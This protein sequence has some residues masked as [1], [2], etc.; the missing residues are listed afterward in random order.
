MN[1]RELRPF[2][3]GPIKVDPSLIL[4]PMSGVTNSCFRRL[5]RRHNPRA[6]GLVVTE[7]ISI[8]GLTRENLRSLEMMRFREEERPISIQIFGHDV[9]RMAEAAKMVEAAGADILDIN[10]GCPVP[11]VVRRG[12]GC[13]LMR[14]PDQMEKI[15]KA[16]RAAIKIPLT[17]KIRSGWNEECIN[18][19]EIARLAE[20]CGVQMLAVHGRTRAQLYRGEADWDVVAKVVEAVKI[21]VVGSGDIVDL[22]SA[23]RALQSG[24]A[25]LM[26]GR[27]ALQNP[28]IFS[29]LSNQ[30]AGVA[31]E[32]RSPQAIFDIIEEYREILMEEA[33]LKA[34]IGRLKQL[35][36][37]CLRDLPGASN[38]RRYLCTAQSLEEFSN[39]LTELRSDL[40]PRYFETE[41]STGFSALHAAS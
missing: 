27:G 36:T 34:I 16:V 4:A 22:E 35:V 20:D 8:E 38:A 18:A 25:G 30:F 9:E 5:V 12:G 28:W 10:S 19:V 11:K 40:S 37:Q 2:S 31:A 39:R 3:I 29:D 13:E 6:L 7:F 23:R 21:P 32:P 14:Q 15:L 24:V 33:P 1:F 41:S 26:I 17:L